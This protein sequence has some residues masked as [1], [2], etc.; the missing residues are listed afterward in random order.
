MRRLALSAYVLLLALFLVFG[1]VPY[2]QKKRDF[3]SAI[4]SPSPLEAI[5]LVDVKPRSA[6]CMSDMAIEP[7]ARQ[8]RF[9]AG[10]YKKA[11][12]PLTVS[13]RGR[14]YS[15][16][17]RIAGGWA[18]NE[19]LVV[20]VPGP[21]SSELLDIC[22]RNEGKVRIALYSSSDRTRSRSVVTTGKRREAANPTFGFWEAKPTTLAS[23]A[24]TTVDRMAVFRG[25]LG[26][27]WIVWAFLVLFA[28]GLSGG[29]GWLLWRAT[30]EQA[31][32]PG[33]GQQHPRE[34]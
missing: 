16:T 29:G 2:L 31:V 22:I 9:R 4:T 32:G 18:D 33:G 19:L 11:G 21:R 25:P 6:V 1:I 23:R 30:G 12:P 5:S 8:A 13:F 7:H 3:A 34:D 10:T 26:H 17:R 15:Y 24:G 14:S 27:P 28:L 20:P